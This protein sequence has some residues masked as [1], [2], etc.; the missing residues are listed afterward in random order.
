MSGPTVFICYSR[1]DKKW[2]DLLLPHLKALQMH[3]LLSVWVD[4]DIQ[5][6]D[7]W[8]PEIEKAIDAAAVAILLISSN[9]LSSKFIIGEEVPF[10]L[11]RRINEGL[12]V[13]P[14][15]IRPCPW[16]SIDWLSPIQ[17]R[18]SDGREISGG[19]DHQIDADF[20]AFAEEVL[21]LIKHTG[22]TTT[23]GKFV[24]LAPEK[25][26]LAKLPK[27]SALLLGREKELEILN[28]AW[29]S[30]T[31]NVVS[32]VA[33]GGEGKTALVK[34]WLNQLRDDDW[35][36]ANRVLG[37]SFYSQGAR[38]DR[39]V[40]ADEFFA[41]ALKRFDDPDPT[42]GSFWE[43]AERLADFIKNH[44]TLLILDG[45]E[46]LQDPSPERLGCIK[47]RG[48]EYLIK[49]LANQNRGL[50]VLTTRLTVADIDDLEGKT[51]ERIDLSHLPDEAGCEL[52]RKLGVK[53]ATDDELLEVVHELAGHA[54]A[55]T[56]LG[57]YVA[58]KYKG[59]IRQRD[60]IP[61]LAK[62]KK[63]GEHARQIMELYAKW[64]K[65]KPELELLHIMGLFD[66]PA[67]GGAIKALREKPAIKGLTSK[68]QKLSDSDWQ[69]IRNN[70]R[71]VN[72]IDPEDPNDPDT[73][74]CHPLIREHFG[75]KLQQN[76]PEAW[77]EAHSRLY[78]Y[79]KSVPEKEHPD[80][81]EEMAPLFAAVGHGCRAGR[82]QEAYA[83][84][85]RQRI[86]RGN[87]SYAVKQLGAV[88]ADLAALS[89]F[90]NVPWQ[91][92]AKAL[93]DHTQMMVLGRAGFELRALGRLQ[94]ATQP[95]EASLEG[96]KKLK[97]WKNAS[98]GA[99]NISELRLLLGNLDQSLGYARQSIKYADRSGVEF[100]RLYMRST[101][102]DTLHQLGCLEEAETLFKEAE[103]MQK[104][105]K[106]EYPILYSFQGF[107]YCDL[108][109]SQGNYNDVLAR[110][111]Q[112]L[113]WEA[114]RRL[115]DIA[116]DHLLLGCAH[117]IIIQ[118]EQGNDFSK[119]VNFLNKAIKGLRAAGI[120]EQI[121][122]G[123]LA[124][125]ELYRVQKEF[126]KAEGD[127]SEA[128]TIATRGG[129][130]L[131]EADCHLEYA[132]LYL[133]MEEKV[134]ARERLETAA[135][136]IAE[137]EYHRRDPE[138]QLAY[139]QLHFLESNKDKAREHLDNAQKMIDEMGMHRW[140]KDAADLAKVLA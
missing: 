108:L 133:A 88:C 78:E 5:A 74:D 41:F 26:S 92:P 70:L 14:V 103:E 104:V 129:M 65:N 126:P 15:I 106:P 53:N 113:K 128:I 124:R 69:D 8:K 72:L 68:I 77:K 134:K 44:R 23:T 47:D 110:A 131:H 139:A 48:L 28:A 20:S 50:C 93:K 123:L 79:Y 37:W 35:R 17:A 55:L 96:I 125:A 18:P 117:L 101:A 122:R 43:K 31:T 52:L 29:S 127:I 16:K 3:D 116:L 118:T 54:L 59:D 114:E 136:M 22:P 1:K 99:S 73:L 34:E 19:D 10:I 51:V 63:Q 87:E 24:R 21:S 67:P 38:E 100:T 82:Y 112:M 40:S 107:R 86:L 7:D 121:S 75:E 85:Y 32:M 76:N 71:E 66:R 111:E 95:M 46:P 90:F 115:L 9:F 120:Q 140:D 45:L 80:T 62:E 102:A 6:S 84:V 119:A 135:G 98:M 137:M 13:F 58:V 42:Q 89:S 138:V 56:L 33:W 130:C 60:K 49:E 36:G 30:P 97:D 105:W 83:Q 132:R 39:Q 11:E 4:S 64:Y 12:R 94:E 81:I 57:R 27:T 91:T 61:A 25:I 2:L 109:L